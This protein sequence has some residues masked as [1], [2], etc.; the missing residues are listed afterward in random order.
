MGPLNSL[1]LRQN[2]RVVNQG[3]TVL[4]TDSIRHLATVQQAS[5]ADSM[6]LLMNLQMVLLVTF[7]GLGIIAPLAQ[8]YQ[9]LVRQ[10][11]T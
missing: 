5:F 6:P 3:N 10:E 9:S 7:V 4:R 11:H 1:A 2:A 8:P